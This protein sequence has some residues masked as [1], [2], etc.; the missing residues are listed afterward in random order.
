MPSNKPIIAVRTNE[1]IIEKFKV[2]CQ[3]E[4]RSMAKQAEK[5]IL[6]LIAAYEAEHGEIKI[7]NES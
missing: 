2:V 1:L 7:D 4:N 6:D 5:M 3:K